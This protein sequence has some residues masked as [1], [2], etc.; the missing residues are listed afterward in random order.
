MQCTHHGTQAQEHAADGH[1]G[2]AL[3]VL[4]GSTPLILLR[5]L[6]QLRHLAYSP[7]PA[8]PARQLHPHG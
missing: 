1:A 2:V 6:H 8:H 3:L 5:I 4:G 7:P